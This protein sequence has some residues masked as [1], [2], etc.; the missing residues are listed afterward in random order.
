MWLG[1]ADPVPSQSVRLP[2]VPAGRGPAPEAQER[3]RRVATVTP[4]RPG[5]PA[6]APV[7]TALP[8]VQPVPDVVEETAKTVDGLLE[9][10]P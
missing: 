4:S 6:T 1:T 5:A 9:R 10:K 7:E 3:P 8:P 2:S